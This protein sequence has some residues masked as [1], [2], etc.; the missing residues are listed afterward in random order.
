MLDTAEPTVVDSPIEMPTAENPG[1]SPIESLL[2][3]HKQADVSTS[4]IE[5]RPKAEVIAPVVAADTSAEEIKQL[6]EMIG[7]DLS[8]FK[9]PESARLAAEM[10]LE[11]LANAG[12]SPSLFAAPQE[13]PA[14]AV[15][16]SDDLGLDETN[17]DPALLKVLKGFKAEN[18]ELK[19]QFA[20]KEQAQK[21]EQWNSF[22]KQTETKAEVHLDKLESPVFGKAG[23][24]TL[25]QNFAYNNVMDVAVSLLKGLIVEAQRMGRTKLPPIETVVDF[26]LRQVGVDTKPAAKAAAVAP[27][28]HSLAPKTAAA[29]IGSGAV[30]SMRVSAGNDPH[31][32]FK[33]DA[34]PII[35]ALWLDAMNGS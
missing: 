4:E 1:R 6:G 35:R 16:K 14:A 23:S 20:Q 34:D 27:K 17:I 30:K 29:G 18:A 21:A 15:E 24:R 8:R 12:E 5:V 3:P 25:A 31:G 13:E 32:F 22:I 9:D 26:A 19:K 28:G 33:A 10:H 2:E 7:V 11:R